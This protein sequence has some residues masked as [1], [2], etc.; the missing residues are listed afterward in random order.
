[1]NNKKASILITHPIA[2]KMWHPTKNADYDVEDITFGSEKMVWW[3]YPYDDPKTGKHF[4]FEWKQQV[5]SLVKTEICPFLQNKRLWKGYND[6]ETLYP[7]IAA[8]WHPTKNGK[9]LP[10]DVFGK[11]GKKVWWYLPYDDPKTGKHFDFEWQ[12]YIINRTKNSQGC[13]YL[14]NSNGKVWIGFNDLATT[15]PYL[16]TEW[17]PTKNGNLKPTDVSAGNGKKVWWYLPYDDPKTGKHFDFEWEASIS[18]RSNNNNGCPYLSNQKI[19]TGYNDL[20]TINPKLASEWHPTKNGNLTPEE[21]GVGYKKKVWWQLPYDDP[22][23]DKHYDFEWK[24]SVYSRHYFGTGCP[25]LDGKLVK[26]GFNDLESLQPEIANEWHPTKN[27]KLKPDMVPLCC[28]KKV[29]WLC[30]F[31]HEW[32]TEVYNRSRIGLGCPYCSGKRKIEK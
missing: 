24:V 20:K 31:G 14:A 23:T 4:D 12:A 6:L 32:R 5:C 22:K 7:K 8:E 16:A 27:R 21:V 19:W 13:P 15:H 29:W 18:S 10:S 1:M 11:A 17:H 30:E 25:Y 9:L 3:F 26:K 2:A 28:A